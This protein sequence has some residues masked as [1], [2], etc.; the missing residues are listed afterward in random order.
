MSKP[1]KTSAPVSV[2][3]PCYRCHETLERACLSVLNQIL[4]P[5]QI[6][7]VE[8]ASDDGG[9]TSEKINSLSRKIEDVWGIECTTIFLEQNVGPGEARNY[10][11]EAAKN[12]FIAFL[13]ADDTWHPSKIQ[14]QLTWMKANPLID[15]TCHQSVTFDRYRHKLSFDLVKVELE[16]SSMLYRNKIQTRTVMLKKALQNRFLKGER[17]SED[18][19][20]W[21]VMLAGKKRAT[22]LNIELASS[23]RPEYSSGG[24]SAKI[25]KMEY[26]ELAIYHDLYR[27]KKITSL[28]FIS[29]TLFSLIKFFIRTLKSCMYYLEIRFLNGLRS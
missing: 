11:W 15:L 12:D 18:Y 5:T 26:S 4:I 2:V 25:W 27:D 13:D 10:G 7:L 20:L 3:I 8:D 14:I 1:Q 23:Y 19:R 24:Q 16:F 17:F 21:L 28:R 9:K 6:I 29:S 22:L